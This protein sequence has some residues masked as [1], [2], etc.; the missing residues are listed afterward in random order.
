MIIWIPPPPQKKKKKKKKGNG[1]RYSFYDY[2]LHVQ[3]IILINTRN[4]PPLPPKK[5]KN[6]N[7]HTPGYSNLGN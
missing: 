6:Q 4:Y 7:N 3:N 1:A 5:K 2:R